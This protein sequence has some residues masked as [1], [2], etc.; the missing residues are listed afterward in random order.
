MH[1]QRTIRRKLKKEKKK[2]EKKKRKRVPMEIPSAQ[3]VVMHQR[4]L[5]FIYVPKFVSL[6]F[7]FRRPRG[8]T[9]TWW[10]CCS[11]CFWHKPTELSHSF[12]FCSCVYIS[13]Y[14]PFN[15]VLFYKLSWQLSA[16]S[17]CSSGL[18]SAILVLSTIYIYLY[19]NKVSSFSSDVIL[20]GWLALKH[21]LTN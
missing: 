18:I 7:M 14:G 9:I 10:G 13:L 6:D 20:C 16:F 2:K 3:L 12:L 21:Q 11:L 17:L 15:S 4:S 8:L 19:M 5:Y 1:C